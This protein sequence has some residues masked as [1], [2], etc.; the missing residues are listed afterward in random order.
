MSWMVRNNSEPISSNAISEAT[1]TSVKKELTMR[2]SEQMDW[3][4]MIQVLRLP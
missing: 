3:L 1:V 2:M 4:M